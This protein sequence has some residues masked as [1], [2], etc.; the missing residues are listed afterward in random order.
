MPHDSTDPQPRS[1]IDPR[2]ILLAVVT[3][4]A[5]GA[6]YEGW[7]LFGPRTGSGVRVADNSKEV[8]RLLEERAR[9]KPTE[10]PGPAP[11]LDERAP[12]VEPLDEATTRTLRPELPGDPFLV[13]DPVLQFRRVENLTQTRVIEDADGGPYEYKTNSLGLRNDADVLAEKPE[14]RILV[15]G[16]S[17]VDGVCRN[18]DGFPAALGSF[19]TNAKPDRAVEVLNAGVGG[20]NP[21]NYLFALEKYAELKPD[22]FVVVIYGGNDFSGMMTLQRYYERRPPPAMQPYTV[23]RFLRQEGCPK[24]MVPQEMAQVM[25]FLNN[26]DDEQVAIDTMNAISAEIVRRCRALGVKPLFV[27]LPPASVGQPA[28]FAVQLELAVAA[29][30]LQRRAVGVS[31]RIADAWL[32]FLGKKQVLA[33]DLRPT[34]RA[35]KTRFYWL[36]DFHINVAGQR[37]AAA[38]V[39]PALE[40]LL[41]G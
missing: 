11:A 2:F 5:L 13:Y 18:S 15:T 7:R 20:Y 35:S 6:A 1:S 22:V 12:K 30:E 31:D 14:L 3:V 25:Y 26:P 37:A 41:H 28:T 33:V 23:D 27:Y 24:G 32:A 10:A 17:H 4:L 21:Y 39:H 29:L 16:D 36:A 40:Q 19:L 38:T 34:F 8:A 9:E